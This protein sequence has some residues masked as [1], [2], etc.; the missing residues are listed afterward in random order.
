MNMR[1]LLQTI[2]QLEDKNVFLLSNFSQTKHG[3]LSSGSYV[4]KKE[5]PCK[6]GNWVQVEE[7]QQVDLCKHKYR[8]TERETVGRHSNNESINP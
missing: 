1:L 8:N 5:C 7:R 4:G 6:F 3:E 2:D